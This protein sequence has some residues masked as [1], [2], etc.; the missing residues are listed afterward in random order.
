MKRLIRFVCVGG[1]GFI[2]DAGLT[3]GLQAA[4]LD[5]FSSR[6]IAIILAMLVTWRLNRSLT[7]GASQ[8]SQMREGWRYISVAT[9]AALL[10]Y[11]VYIGLMLTIPGMIAFLAVAAAT[12]VSMIVSYLGYSQ[13][14]FK[15]T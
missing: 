6:L 4:G 5:I 13:W 9:A 3:I 7:F 14:V 15:V 10:N 12:S 2:V 1:T 8:T 11:A